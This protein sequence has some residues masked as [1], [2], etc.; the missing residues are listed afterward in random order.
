MSTKLLTS[1]DFNHLELLNARLQV[2]SS[3]PGSAASGWVYFNSVTGKLRV[4]NGS[5]WDEMGSGG[6]SVTSVSVV[7]ANGF[8]GTV[9]NASTTPAITIKT[10][11]TGLLKG[12][13]TAISAATAGTDYSAGT[14]ALGTGILKSTTSTGALSIAVAGDFPTLNQNTT[15]TAAGFTGSLA[16][17]VTGTQSATALANTAGVQAIIRANRLDQMAAPTAS[18]S[19][20]S[21]KATNLLDP[22]N[23]Q[24]AATKAYVDASAQGLDFKASVR[25]ATTA[26]GTLAS[27]FA[28]G[29][30]IDGVTLATGNRILIKNQS[31]ASENGIYTVNASGAPTRA[32][33][34][35]AS[36]EISKGACVFVEE[37]TAN[38]GQLW[39][40]TATGASPW[41]PGSSTS[42]WTQFAGAADIT[43]TAPI[44]KTGN[45][46]GINLGN[47]LTT[48][49]SNLVV[50]TAVVARKYS[51]LIGNGSS[52]S[53]TVTHSLGTKDIVASVRDA[54]TDAIVMCDIVATST[55][56]A[57]FTFATAPASN[58]Y[59]VTII[60]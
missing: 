54:S 34:A 40:C 30:T 18:V 3:D 2:L 14:S 32:I 59:R 57:T 28:N 25:V 60:G 17:D 46:I 47:G 23:P 53:I 16:G 15:G 21:Q 1:F 29:Q 39:L 26:N 27:A 44:T 36:G 56:Q 55:T 8:D 38:A 6:G 33:D 48:S 35:D 9:A 50:D 22:T 58:A 43:A 12:N 52:A 31:A 51:S 24:D 5:T 4:Y 42:T 20:N 45:A 7:A 41:V 11:I 10:T 13:G 49:G 19:F 37:G